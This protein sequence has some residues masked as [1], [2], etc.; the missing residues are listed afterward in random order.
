MDEALVCLFTARSVCAT[1]S[2]AVS[3]RAKTPIGLC[4]CPLGTHSLAG[5]PPYHSL[6]SPGV[7]V[8]MYYSTSF[9]KVDCS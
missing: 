6:F 2:C 1:L 4:R 8:D 7:S 9:A 3:F 5:V